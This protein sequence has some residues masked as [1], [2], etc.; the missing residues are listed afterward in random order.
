MDMKT[1]AESHAIVDLF[2]EKSIASTPQKPC[3][4][5]GCH[6]CCHEAMYASQAEVE[7]ILESLTPAQIDDLKPKLAEW[8]VR[9]SEL[10]KVRFPKVEQYLGAKIPCVLLE[11]G[12]CSVYE[13][14]PFGCRVWFAIGD[15]ENCKLPMRRNQGIAQ[16]SFDQLFAFIGPP[17]PV[18]GRFILDHLGVLLAEKILG[19]NIPSASRDEVDATQMIKMP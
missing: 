10:R 18:N 6:T 15:P 3:C 1:V 9:T 7:Y 13:R 2:V 16:F 19:L 17:A 12:L 5:A 8:L 11:N 14:R 4:R